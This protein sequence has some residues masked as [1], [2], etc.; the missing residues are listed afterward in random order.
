MRPGTISLVLNS[1]Q[2]SPLNEIQ[3][4]FFSFVSNGEAGRAEKNASVWPSLLNTFPDFFSFSHPPNFPPQFFA[5][6]EEENEKFWKLGQFFFLSSNSKNSRIFIPI[7]ESSQIFLYFFAG[8]IWISKRIPNFNTFFLSFDADRSRSILDI[9]R[10]SPSFALIMPEICHFALWLF[11]LPSNKRINSSSSS[12]KFHFFRPDFYSLIEIRF[13]RRRTPPRSASFL[14]PNRS[15]S[16]PFRSDP[17]LGT[18]RE[19]ILIDRRTFLI[20]IVSFIQYLF[21]PLFLDD[22]SEWREGFPKLFFLPSYAWKL[23]IQREE[24]GIKKDRAYAWKIG[25]TMWTESR[26][27]VEAV[28]RINQINHSFLSLTIP[29]LPIYPRLYKNPPLES[30]R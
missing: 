8:R 24:R 5:E 23:M 10:L 19:W 6:F 25:S 20:E 14:N 18:V 13:S 7:I 16:L 27:T 4:C 30:K 1:T 11:A 21:V 17:F 15:L 3:A 9:S 2:A 12:K 22:A 26:R 28:H 29:Y